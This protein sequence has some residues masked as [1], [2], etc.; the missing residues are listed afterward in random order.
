MEEPFF[1]FIRLKLRQGGLGSRD[2]IFL[3]I[4]FVGKFKNLKRKVSNLYCLGYPKTGPFS[5]KFPSPLMMALLATGR[6][7]FLA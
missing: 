1:A 3:R 4:S 7:P 2:F 5:G 6:R